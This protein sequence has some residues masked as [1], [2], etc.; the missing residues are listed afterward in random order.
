M[1]EVKRKQRISEYH[2]V[3]ISHRWLLSALLLSL[4]LLWCLPL[5]AQDPPHWVG[6]EITIDCTSQCHVAHHAGPGVGLTQGESNVNLCLSC[7]NAA[8][9]AQ[10]FPLTIADQA[11][12]G[13]GGT[14]H[15][16]NV[17]ATQDFDGDTVDDVLPPTDPEMALRLPGDE[18]ICSTCHNQHS[19]EAAR[20]GTP[21]VGSA[22]QVTTLG[23]TGTLASGGTFS[24]AE[25]LWYLIEIQ[26]GADEANATFCY[27][28]D[29]GISWFPSGCTPPGETTDNLSADGGNP[30]TLDNGVSVTFGAGNYVAGERWEFSA[31]WPF[32]RADLDT[33]GAGS[34]MC[35]D[36]HRNWDLQKTDIATWDGTPNSHPVRQAYQAGTDGYYSDAPLDGNGNQQNAA[37]P[38]DVDGNPSN[39]LALHGSNDE[40]QCLSC[41]GVHHVDS[42]TETV[43]GPS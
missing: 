39:D 37:G 42:N 11:V 9:L 33:A 15:A 28:K 30:V 25:G 34:V 23:S 26:E 18:I 21:R 38:P 5:A 17:A 4:A 20:G 27:S 2:R 31:A 16:F 41:H 43:D 8:G 1:P 7:H 35:R 32:L 3:G 19:A 36:C 24:G 6:T 14:S 40:V 29:T 13:T 10:D 12:P 22:N